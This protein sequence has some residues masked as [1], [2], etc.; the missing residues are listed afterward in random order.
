MQE[1]RGCQYKGR[2]PWISTGNPRV[3]SHSLYFALHGLFSISD[4]KEGKGGG[5]GGGGGGAGGCFNSVFTI[6]IN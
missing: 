1:R 2:G 5:R 4:V 6:Y 3:M